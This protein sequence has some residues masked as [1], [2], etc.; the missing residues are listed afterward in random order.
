MQLLLQQRPIDPNAV[1][2]PGS[3]MSALH[4]AASYVPFSFDLGGL[5][6]VFIDLDV[7]TLSL[8]S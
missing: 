6:D 8:Y 3:G 7:R 4:L 2:P 1:D 5:S